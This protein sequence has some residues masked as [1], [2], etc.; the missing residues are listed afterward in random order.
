MHYRDSSYINN[1]SKVQCTDSAI[2]AAVSK[3]AYLFCPSTQET[4]KLF[5]VQIHSG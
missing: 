1:L 5:F 4:W 3:K 2:Y